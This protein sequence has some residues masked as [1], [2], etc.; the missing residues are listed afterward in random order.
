M[1]CMSTHYKKILVAFIT[2][3]ILIITPSFAFAQQSPVYTD[4]TGAK[5]YDSSGNALTREDLKSIDYERPVY[6]EDGNQLSEFQVE[7]ARQDAVKKDDAEVNSSNASGDEDCGFDC[8]VNFLNPVNMIPR[9]LK[10]AGVLALQILAWITG[11]AGL[12]MNFAI[13]LSILELPKTLATLN[14]VI[15]NVWAVLRDFI[16]M[17]FIFILLWA[18]VNTIL[19]TNKVNLKETVGNLI[20]AAI[21]MNFSM[22]IAKVILDV[23][24]VVAVGIWDQIPNSGSINGI[25][26][27]IMR[28]LNLPSI[29]DNGA[30]SA[31]NFAK[32]MAIGNHSLVDIP[33]L[34]ITLGGGALL[35]LITIFTFLAG[36]IMLILRLVKIIKVLVLSPLAFSGRV[37]PQLKSYSNSWWKDL[38]DV[39]IF[40]PV[41]MLFLWIAFSILNS[42]AYTST[43][44]PTASNPFSFNGLAALFTSKNPDEHM[45]GVILNFIIIISFML[46][47]LTQAKEYSALGADTL[48]DWKKKG[49]NM[50]LGVLSRGTVGK[51]A[52]MAANSQFVKRLEAWSPTI[53]RGV[54]RNLES[55]SDAKMFGDSYNQAIKTKKADAKESYKKTADYVKDL[56]KKADE[57]D[58]EFANRKASIMDRYLE[59]EKTGSLGGMIVRGVTRDSSYRTAGEEAIAKQLKE[60]GK[61]ADKE[62]KD[63]ENMEKQRE[64]IAKSVNSSLEHLKSMAGGEAGL[65]SGLQTALKKQGKKGEDIAKNIAKKIANKE[66]K[67]EDEEL[68]F[69]RELNEHLI[70]EERN[71]IA[72]L[73]AELKTIDL[74][75][76]V[77][78]ADE[79]KR[80]ESNLAAIESR[81]SLGVPKPTDAAEKTSIKEKLEG[82]MKSKIEAYAKI[83]TDIERI[84]DAQRAR[85]NA[86][87]EI[88]RLEDKEERKKSGGGE[89]KDEGKKDDK[90]K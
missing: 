34:L 14:P 18:A 12:I 66:T 73:E 6:D 89:K 36:A 5:L 41:F 19:G 51:G 82:S 78:P 23:S 52:N 68:E 45:F 48:M 44:M 1:Y 26:G 9:A 80:L 74:S 72:N 90:K 47:S 65:N 8:I 56:K 49:T 16:N 20:I 86:E 29:F 46:Q 57:T 21:F 59:A 88:K 24:S 13:K 2:G 77:M 25:S 67:F 81:A 85:R 3:L 35:M 7:S 4:N 83:K 28:G 53:G 76:G 15:Q 22:V 79:R 42:P 87:Q 33:N 32:Q 64:L 30:S 40:P 61:E 70:E 62:K 38:M 50:T 69:V 27:M 37:L 58:E 10:V 84:Q 31:F 43:I 60:S 75:A 63:A 54:R 17:F 39:A 11:G 71:R 55:V